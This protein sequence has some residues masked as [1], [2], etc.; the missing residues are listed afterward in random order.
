MPVRSDDEF[1]ATVRRTVPFPV[2]DA[3]LDTAIHGELLTAVHAHPDPAVTDAFVVPPSRGASYEPGDR[4]NV[5]A[6]GAG[7]C[8]GAGGVGPGGGGP[9]GVG[10]VGGV[11]VG[12]VGAGGVGGVG[13]V[14]P[15]GAGGVGPGGVGGVGPGGVGG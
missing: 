12:G 2:P 14:G 15:G 7:G 5:H 8:G 9:G 11:G 6:G 13:G 3:P 1:A 4:L 10:G